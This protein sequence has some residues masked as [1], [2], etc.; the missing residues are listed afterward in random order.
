MEKESKRVINLRPIFFCFASLL[1]ALTTIRYVLAGDVVYIVLDGIIFFGG[2]L[3]FLLRKKFAVLL[4]LLCSFT[5]G[6]G[7]HFVGMATFR[8]NVYTEE[9]QIVGRISDDLSLKE[10]YAYVTLKDVKINDQN[11]KNIALLIYFTGCDFEIGD[12]IT[13]SSYVK[14]AQ[15]YE[16]G[17]FNSTYY[18]NR[19]GYT[20]N[21]N[22][23]N[24][25][26]INHKLT[27]AEKVR[28]GVK[29]LLYDKLGEDNGA[30]AYAVMFGD[31]S[32]VDH[33]IKDTYKMAGII[34]ILT[35]S[36][37]HVSFL[38]ACLG[39]LL[40]KC[41]IK[42]WLNLSICSLIVLF[43]AYLCGFSPSV[44]RAS[45]MGLM[46]LATAIS[47][48]W[49]DG[50]NSLSLAGI[51]ILLA[52]PLSANDVGF[53]MS[54]FCV[55]GIF[56]LSPTLSKIFRK[57]LP[58]YIAEACAVSIAAEIGILPF[59][60]KIFLSVNIFAPL[61]NLVVIPIFSI[62][63]P[64][65]LISVL[66]TSV[67]GFMGF[68]L[69]VCGFGLDAT[70]KIAGVFANKY[71]VVELNSLKIYVVVMFILLLFLASRYFMAKRRARTVCLVVVATLLCGL[72]G[73]S[74]MPLAL[75]PSISFCTKYQNTSVLLTNKAQE[76]VIINLAGVDFTKKMLNANNVTKV[77]AVF[78]VYSENPTV[79]NL[80]AIGNPT[81]VLCDDEI[82][83]D[84]VVSV[85]KNQIGSVGKFIFTYDDCGLEIKF[86]ETVVYVLRQKKLN[87]TELA[88]IASKNYDF[89]VTN[90]KNYKTNVYTGATN[91]IS[92][93]NTENSDWSYL[94]DG[95]GVYML[96]TKKWRCLD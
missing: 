56:A 70:T 29:A 49:Y 46:L 79:E 16:L 25:Y 50:L 89:V 61:I 80:T 10:N 47:G 33:E 35:I 6:V 41:R 14:Q 9:C 86:D 81:L 28:Q 37:L 52:N 67:M 65:L 73:L 60:S 36:G 69:K 90:T 5:F 45:I 76:S 68:M 77:S 53:L 42:G 64:L 32:A 58:K 84:G 92:Y 82:E 30:V 19:I 22:E 96:R 48:K 20:A 2:G 44:V 34:H 4:L 40:K 8:T 13:F 1:L 43:Y 71:F 18:R 26:K 57:F 12:V 91:V 72:Y 17:S 39:F 62:L 3:Y 27:L 38:L 21:V 24:L 95:N 55:F 85:S 54:V 87:D 75:Q 66:L 63:Y 51:I 83:Y 88:N 7:W 11:E 15:L 93:Y 94:K 59:L 31:K 78:N 74:F 23:D